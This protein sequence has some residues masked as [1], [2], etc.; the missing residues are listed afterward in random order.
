MR[1]GKHP[2]DALTPPDITPKPGA[3]FDC[4]GCRRCVRARR[5][6]PG[7]RAEHHV[8]VA[9]RRLVVGLAIVIV[10]A[11]VAAIAAAL[12]WAG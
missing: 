8:G 5:T 6:T 1:A 12:A 9:D 11:I 3:R 7:A 2:T 10:V 4:G